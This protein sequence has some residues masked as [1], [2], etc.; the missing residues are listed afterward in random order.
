MHCLRTMKWNEPKKTVRSDD[1]LP[2]LHFSYDVRAE[3]SLHSFMPHSKPPLF[4]ISSLDSLI[5]EKKNRLYA[6]QS[7]STQLISCYTITGRMVPQKHTLF[8][9]AAVD[10]WLTEE[11]TVCLRVCVCMWLLPSPC[12]ALCP[13]ALLLH[14]LAWHEWLSPAAHRRRS[15]RNFRLVD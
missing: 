1:L 7:K 10:V 9:P 11:F 12:Q 3:L 8:C 5:I 13:F 14:H 15:K 4:Y 2:S 6:I